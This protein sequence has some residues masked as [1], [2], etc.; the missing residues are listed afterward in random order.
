MCPQSV[1]ACIW[2]VGVAARSQ[3]NVYKITRILGIKLTRVKYWRNVESPFWNLIQF[4]NLQSPFWNLIQFCSIQNVV[5]IFWSYPFS[6]TLDSN[7]YRLDGQVCLDP[8]DPL[9]TYK[10]VNNIKFGVVNHTKFRQTWLSRWYMFKTNLSVSGYI[11]RKYCDFLI[12]WK[13]YRDFTK[14][15]A[16]LLKSTNYNLL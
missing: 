4:W 9:F 13:F 10:M 6:W 5:K 12:L 8:L 3:L 1:L 14:T 7:R 15:F 11:L 2:A 16:L